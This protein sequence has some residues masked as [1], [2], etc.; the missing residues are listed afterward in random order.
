MTIPPELEAFIERLNLEL[1]EI[2]QRVSVGFNLTRELLSRFPDYAILIQNFAYFNAALF[3]VNSSRQQIQTI[4]DSTS[5]SETSINQIQETGEDLGTL[6]GQAIEVKL[7]VE[8]LVARLE[9]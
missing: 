3:F 2:E 4:I 7:R 1:S 5:T 6:F 9:E 8:R